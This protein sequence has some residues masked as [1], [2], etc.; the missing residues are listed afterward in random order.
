MK[1]PYIDTEKE[2][3]NS[4]VNAVNL[5]SKLKQT[6]PSDRKDFVDGIHICQKVLGMRILRRDYPENFPTY[7]KEEYKEYY[8]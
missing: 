4:L 7:T 3:M 2:I 1:E 8:D 5:F 6:H